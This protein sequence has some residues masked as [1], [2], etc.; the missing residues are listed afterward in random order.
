MLSALRDADGADSIVG[1]ILSVLADAAW[2]VVT[3]FVVPL[4][5]LEG[6]TPIAAIK[7]SAGLVRE[8]WGEGVVGSAATGAVVLIAALPAAALIVLGFLVA[9][10]SFARGRA[11]PLR[12]AFPRT[13]PR[14]AR[15]R[16]PA[17]GSPRRRGSARSG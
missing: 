9:R 1:S 17:A 14:G 12:G 16:A 6:L 10:P 4:L 13:L 11:G 3:F 5:A 2:A 7:R 15:R 8:R